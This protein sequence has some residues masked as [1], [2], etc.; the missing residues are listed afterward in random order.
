MAPHRPSANAISAP[1][2]YTLQVS[3]ADHIYFDIY[4]EKSIIMT[5]HVHYRLGKDVHDGDLQEFGTTRELCLL[6]RGGRA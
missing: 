6:Y 1:T 4:V 2:L 5:E 3:Q